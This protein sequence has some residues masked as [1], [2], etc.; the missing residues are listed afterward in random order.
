MQ[1]K[2]LLSYISN[3]KL[4]SC[5]EHVICPVV[6]AIEEKE[7]TLYDNVIDP[8]S[9]VFDSIINKISLSQWLEVEKSRQ[10]HKTLQNGIGTFHQS[11]IGNIDGWEDLGTGQIVDLRNK[12][13]K[14][15]AEV[16]NK[17]NTTKGNHKP[18]IYDD[19]KLKLDSCG[20]D[21]YIGYYVEV[22]RKCRTK[23]CKP[24]TPSDNTTHE[25]RPEHPRIKV[26]DGESFYTLATGSETAL[27]DL[28]RVL[29]KIVCEIVGYDIKMDEMYSIL[30]EKA[31]NIKP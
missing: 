23:Y 24:F 14:I 2:R 29:P 15:I 16:K 8:F 3:E 1:T 25:K 27:V 18:V 9:A 20:D 31:Y 6:N 7:Q 28:Y 22:I 5:V 21:Q 10:V 30:F 19:L 17:Y 4:Y 12:E 11:L 26:I 13:R